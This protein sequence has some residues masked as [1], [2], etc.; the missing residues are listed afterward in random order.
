MKYYTDYQPVELKEHKI[1]Y[2]TMIEPAFADTETSNTIIGEGALGEDIR[3]AWLYLWGIM[4]GDEIYIG[5]KPSEMMTFLLRLVADYELGPKRQLP[6][7]IHN[8]P[9]DASYLMDF[10]YE[11]LD[12]APEI[13]AVA[14]QRPFCIRTNVGIEFRCSYKMVNKSLDKWGKDLN[15]EH[16][17]KV[18]LKDYSAIY[19]QSDP[20]PENELEYFQYDLLSMKECYYKE[21][22]VRGYHYWDV[23]YTVTGFVRNLFK[24][25][26]KHGYK[27]GYV[28]SRNK[29]IFQRT[30]PTA[31]QYLRLVDASMGGMTE[32][33]IDCIGT[34]VHWDQGIGH[35]DFDSHYPT[36]QIQR[37][38][39]MYP[40]TIKDEYAAINKDR[41]ITD[42][43]LT[44]YEKRGYVW[45]AVVILSD[46]KLRPGIT[47]PFLPHSK[48]KPLSTAQGYGAVNGKITSLQGHWYTTLTNLDYRT[49]KE[50][51][52]FRMHVVCL[53]IY[54]TA[55]LPNYVLDVVKDLYKG[56]TD[57]KAVVGKLEEEVA[58]RE[59][60]DDAKVNLLLQKGQL[61]G[62]F[63]CTYT[64]I[65]REQITYDNEDHS[66]SIKKPNIQEELDKYYKRYDSCLAYQWGVFTTA[67]ARRQLWECCKVIQKA[68]DLE[69][70]T[71]LYMDTDSI[72]YRSTPAIQEAIAEY[73]K[74]C[75]RLSERY[76]FCIEKADGSKKYFN[77]FDSEHDS[78]KSKTFRCLHAKCYALEPDGEL[79]CTI[80]GVS[81]YAPDGSTREDELGSIENMKNDF[82]FEKCGGT[83]ADYTTL[84]AIHDYNGNE[85]CGGCIILPNVKTLHDADRQED[86]Y[87]YYGGVILDY[88]K[89]L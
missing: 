2:R 3:E 68:S 28:M 25:R 69:D 71:I 8:L 80:A 54:T 34:T 20:L 88:A 36:Q 62:V 89:I 29:H 67:Y 39:P 70:A 52:T 61:N 84:S 55:H 5:R 38:F 45:V 11:Y 59:Q 44:N 79:K 58:A 19:N 14:P 74:K 32:C 64:K 35:N 9:Y 78:L 66:W 42:K 81:P 37:L 22:Q 51:Y 7:Y 17:K 82:R 87:N 65:A 48:V 83:Y 18:G 63:G 30:K 76:G 27:Y 13:Y 33:A 10:I 72:F 85:T 21:L 23:P 26:Y 1:K 86:Y 73:N 16:K 6:V 60:I 77:K 75:R 47:T 53:D 15:I 57:L 40:T 49:Y 4:V 46:L 50:Q 31:D 24:D 12:D 41:I 56:K 43:D